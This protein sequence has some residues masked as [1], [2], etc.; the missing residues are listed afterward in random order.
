MKYV[1][2]FFLI[3]V[4]AFGKGI[5][6]DAFKV[7]TSTAD[8]KPEKKEVM[9]VKTA[10]VEIDFSDT[11][12]EY[13]PGSYTPPSTPFSRPSSNFGLNQTERANQTARGNNPNL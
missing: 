8:M 7:D 13:R 11:P 1:L 10:P 5:S 2:I 3:S 9:A 6:F 12:K 4:S